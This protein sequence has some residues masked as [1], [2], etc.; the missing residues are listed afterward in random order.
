MRPD[1]V[2]T[3]LSGRA[4]AEYYSCLGL[5]WSGRSAAHWIVLHDPPSLVG[6]SLLVSTLDRKGGRHVGVAASSAPSA[7]RWSAP[8]SAGSTRSSCS[9]PSARGCWPTATRRWIRSSWTYRPNPYGLPSSGWCTSQSYATASG[10]EPVLEAMA[11]GPAEPIL[12]VGHLSPTDEDTV[13]RTAR[14][15]GLEHRLRLLGR[16][17]DS[18]SRESFDTAEIVVRHRR[19]AAGNPGAISGPITYTMAAGYAVV[20]ADAGDGQLP[21]RRRRARPRTGRTT[22]CPRSPRCWAI[23]SR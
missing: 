18:A 22:W 10:V 4:L 9:R 16:L 20:T 19:Q 2:V 7:S 15:L 5:T 8:C 14:R 11:L 6:P 17:D 12:H 13:V 3:Q 21:D 1:L 23:P